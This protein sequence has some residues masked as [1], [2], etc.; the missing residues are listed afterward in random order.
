MGGW[1]QVQWTEAGQIT[2]RLGWE[3]SD[4]D[5]AA[6]PETYFARLRGAGRLHDAAFFLGQALPRFEA[7]AWAA[8]AVRDLGAQARL[9]GPDA[10]ALK[11]ALLWVQDPSEPRRRAAWD[12]AALAGG[13]APERLTALA[14]FFSG[15]SIAPADCNPVPAPKE[16]AGRFGAGAVVLAAL[17]RGASANGLDAALDAGVAVANGGGS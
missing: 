9:P 14:V 3:V 6:S 2:A 4:A 7:V 13:Q 12:A 10:D 17:R 5:A 16:A 11:A 1:A 15:G 8:R